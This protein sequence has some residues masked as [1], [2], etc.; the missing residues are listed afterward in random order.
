MAV[1]LG[2][3]GQGRQIDA[4]LG[5]RFARRVEPVRPFGQIEYEHS[6]VSQCASAVS[7]WPGRNSGVLGHPVATPTVIGR[8]GVGQQPGLDLPDSA[9]APGCHAWANDTAAIGPML[10]RDARRIMRDILSTRFRFS[11]ASMKLILAAADNR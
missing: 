11:I 1:M 9:L 8:V 4:G 5:S 3:A 7:G 10:F 2:A 6:G